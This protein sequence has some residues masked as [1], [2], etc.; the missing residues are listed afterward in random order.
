MRIAVAGG[1]GTVGRYVVEAL[2]DGGHDTVILTRSTGVDLVA[3][4]GLAGALEGV[5]AVVDATSISTQDAAVSSQFFA[6]VTTA[7]LAAEHDA[8]VG[9]HVALSIVGAAAI[10]SGY[11]AGKRVQEELV[12][13]AGDRGT[14]L[15][16]TQFH[17]FVRQILPAGRIGP[18]QIVPRMLSQPI[19]AAEVGAALARLAT[20]PPIGIAP[21]LAGPEVLRMAEMARRLFRSTDSR[22][23]VIEVPLPGTFGRGLR[24]GSI[25]P[26]PNAELGTQTFDEWLR[27]Q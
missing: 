21:D 15:R 13:A 3:D 16:A 4:T 2:A 23:P 26:G 12:I 7:L 20:H 6:A 10:N 25:L 9:H 14:I 19:A 18:V 8:G 5:D 17:E 27:I 22:R 24:D 11:Y 1:T